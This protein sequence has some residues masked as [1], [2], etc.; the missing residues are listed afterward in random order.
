MQGSK[1]TS[2][3]YADQ[4]CI[5][6][7]R[8]FQK[9]TSPQHPWFGYLWTCLAFVLLAGSMQDAHAL[10]LIK[11]S[12]KEVVAKSTLIVQGRVTAKRYVWAPRKMGVVTLVT[13][14]VQEEVIGRKAP[15]E[16]VIRH[17]GGQIGDV[18]VVMPNSPHFEVG[19][20]VIAVLEASQYLPANEYLLVGWTQGQWHILRPPTGASFSAEAIVA[21]SYH[22]LS[23][24]PTPQAQI[25]DPTALTS[26][27]V[28]KSRMRQH[29]QDFQQVKVLPLPTLKILPPAIKLNTQRP[30]PK[31][32]QQIPKIA[33]KQAPL[34]TP[35][36]HTHP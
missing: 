6:S 12:E 17:Y 7:L 3:G 10:S 9:E 34:P 36:K 22:K 24:Y 1:R 8:S 27:R 16:V 11:L 4:R 32:V 2:K 26:L 15:K 25:K 19:Q 5:L 20:E 23:A 33:P 28:L 14:A 35:H 21:R 13:L 31:G 18:R 30:L 29:W